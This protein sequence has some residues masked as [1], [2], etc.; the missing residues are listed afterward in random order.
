[1]TQHGFVKLKD[2]F[3]NTI[4]FYSHLP[5]NQDIDWADVTN[6]R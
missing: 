5:S 6:R 1:M 4:Y 3:E 2:E